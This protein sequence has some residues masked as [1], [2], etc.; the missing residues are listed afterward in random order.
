MKATHPSIIPADIR[1]KLL[2]ARDAHIAGQ[3]DEVNHWI[4]A[5]A[6]PSFECLDPW[7]ALE[8]RSCEC[9]PHSTD[10]TQ[11]EVLERL[12]LETEVE[13]MTDP[14][15]TPAERYPYMPDEHF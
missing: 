5:I 9:G 12:A 10:I 15:E 7:A 13:D 14:Q 8:G 2:L 11:P 4:Y 1:A 6:C 3:Y